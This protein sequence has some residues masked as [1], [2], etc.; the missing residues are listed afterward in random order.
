M[1]QNEINQVYGRLTKLECLLDKPRPPN[2][3]LDEWLFMKEQ[4]FFMRGYYNALKQ[5]Q[6]LSTHH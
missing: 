4:Q 3:S 5:R 6:R 1:L 2:I